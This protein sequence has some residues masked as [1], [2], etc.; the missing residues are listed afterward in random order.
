MKQQTNIELVPQVS[1]I[2]CSKSKEKGPSLIM[3]LYSSRMTNSGMFVHFVP[4][5]CVQSISS[6]LMNYIQ[7]ST[8]T[9]VFLHNQHHFLQVVN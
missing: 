9:S 5:P 4:S 8:F 1:L 7:L 6:A 2:K 3:R